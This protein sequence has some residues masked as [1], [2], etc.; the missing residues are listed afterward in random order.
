MVQDD[1]SD[2]ATNISSQLLGATLLLNPSSKLIQ[3][4]TNKTYK[5]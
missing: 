1:P 2:V 4:Q 5:S 3:P